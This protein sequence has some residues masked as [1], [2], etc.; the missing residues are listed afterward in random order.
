M[1]R[2]LTL[3]IVGVAVAAV[4]LAGLATT[5]LARLGARNDSIRQAS[6]AAQ[7]LVEPSPGQPTTT[8]T[9]RVRLGAL[10]FPCNALQAP[11]IARLARL[12]SVT[13]VGVTD[14]GRLV[15][16]PG[17]ANRAPSLPLVLP[18]GVDLTRFD[19]GETLTSVR[20][21]TAVAV[22]RLPVETG[23]GDGVGA[24]RGAGVRRVAVVV[25]RPVSSPL[26]GNV[27]RWLVVGSAFAAVAGAVLARLLS[28]RLTRPLRAAT[29]A[30]G[31]LAAGDLT[32]RLPVPPTEGGA[33]RD[34][35][36]ELSRS[37][38]ALA[39]SLE[40]SRGLEQRFL[41]SVSHDLRTPLTSIRGYAEA[42]AD[43]TIDDVGKGSAVIL[44]E[45][46]RLERLVR[47]LLDLAR[48]DARS[49][50]L[51]LR[52]VDLGEIARA[53]A[54]A[55]RPDAA[56]AGVEL[57]AAV[58]GEPVPAVGDPDRLAQVVA[59]LV[60][61]A[62][63]YAAG[64]IEVRVS[65]E[66]V[67]GTGGLPVAVAT[68]VVADDGPGIA[69]ED[70]PHVFERLYVSTHAPVRKEAGSGLGLAIVAELV[71]AMGGS[72]AAFENRPTGTAMIVR[73]PTTAA[74]LPSAD[75]HPP[76][77]PAT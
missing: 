61:N 53:A 6:L 33:D 38:N 47:D 55:L 56:R 68:L 16:L 31:R 22:V 20:G 1:T 50:R 29:A 54:E 58:P 51:D 23:T 15:G 75:L 77:T 76:S 44:R 18:D 52:P 36:V 46:N 49:F 42:L 72:V 70:R 57:V 66:Q 35:L 10:P 21:G 4:V 41:L 60:E 17:D 67:A 48:L 3:A 37:I 39:A 24:G 64:R 63:K 45:S 59:N 9:T 34:E 25:V 73:L 65:A 27:V 11:R 28:V 43:G 5:A 2:R 13:C 74:R 62:I 32:V 69:A 14:D 40:R 26:S 12:S 19:A 71:A 30:T 7:A 8:A